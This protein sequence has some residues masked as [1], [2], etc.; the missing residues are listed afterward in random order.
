MFMTPRHPLHRL[1]LALLTTSLLLWAE[2]GR[3]AANEG[4]RPSIVTAKR[5]KN[6]QV[7]DLIPIAIKVEGTTEVRQ[8][9]IRT[10]FDPEFFE[11][12]R[13]EMGNHPEH[14]MICP[15]DPAEGSLELPCFLPRV[16]PLH[17]E[18]GIFVASGGG[19]LLDGDSDTS[20]AG[21]L[22]TMIFR[23]I[24]D[25]G[26]ESRFISVLSV[27]VAVSVD[28]F[29]IRRFD[30]G[31]FGVEAVL[32]FPNKIF[33]V[34]IKAKDI[35]AVATWRTR[36][37]GVDDIVTIDEISEDG[38]FLATVGQFEPPYIDRAPEALQV[39]R[40]LE[41]AGIDVL[42][43]DPE[44]IR[45]FVGFPIPPFGPDPFPALLEE[46]K[47]IVKQFRARLHVVPITGLAPATLYRATIRSTGLSGRDSPPQRA[48]FRTRREPDLRKL[49]A[50][51]LDIQP[52]RTWFAVKFSTNRL[53]KTNYTVATVGGSEVDNGEVNPDGADVTI[54]EVKGLTP[55]TEY[56]VDIVA[57]LAGDIPAE[58]PD[59]DARTTLRKQIKTRLARKALNMAGVPFKIVGPESALIKFKTPLPVA[60]VVFYGPIPLDELSAKVT[61]DGGDMDDRYDWSTDGPATTD[62]EIDLTAL[63]PETEYRYK[64][65][66]ELTD[67]EGTRSFSTDPLGNQQWSRDLQFAT[68]RAD[69]L[70]E[71][72][73]ESGPRVFTRNIIAVVQFENDVPT[74]AVATVGTEATFGTPDQFTFSDGLFSH[75]HSIILSGLEQDEDYLF[76]LEFTAANGVTGTFIGAASGAG[77]ATGARQPPGGGGS[78]TTTNFP[79]TQFPVILSGPT[80][81]SKTHD[82]AI[83]EWTTDEP[84]DSDIQFGTE[85]LDD[86]ETSGV[87]ETDHKITLANLTPGTTYQYIVA[88]TD[89]SGNGATESAQ[90]VFT[91]D[92]EVDLI[93]PSIVGTPAIGYRNDNSATVQWT[94]DEETTGQVEFG[95][96]ADL[97][98]IRTLP[99]TDTAHEITLTNL[100]ASTTYFYKVSSSDLSN[101]G[102]T[103]ST[104]LAFAT[105]AAPD[106]TPPTITNVQVAED[107]TSAILTWDTNE[108]A[109]SF[110]DFGTISGLLTSTVGDVQD[111]KEHEITLTNLAP[112][113]TYFYTVGSVDRANNP[114]RESVQDQFTTLA[115]A[116]VTPPAQP[117]SLEGTEGSEQVVLSWDANDELD[118][119]GY[120]LERRVAGT[121]SFTAIASGL[122]QPTYTDLGLTN[123]TTYEYRVVAVDRADNDSAESAPLSLTPVSSAAP[124][125]PTNL[126]RTG[127]LRPTFRFANAEPFVADATLTYTVQVSTQE[128]FSDV[129]DSESGVAEDSDGLTTWTITRDLVEGG[130]YYW[131][132]RALEGA[133]IGPWTAPQVFVAEAVFLVADF[134]GDLEVNFDDF[135]RFVDVFGDP[136]TGDDA[137][138]DLDHDGSVDFDDFFIFV[139]HFGDTATAG[140]AWAYAHVLDEEAR[141]WLEARGSAPMSAGDGPAA[142][143]TTGAESDR[144]TVRVLADQVRDLE[145][146]ALVVD[147]DPRL[148]RFASAR[149]GAGALLESQG[150]S[151]PLFSVLHQ[152]KGELLMGNGLI[153]GEPVSGHGV[154]AELTF[155]TLATPT[156][157]QSYFE[158][159]EAFIKGGRE[160][161]VR[162]VRDVSSTQLLPQE[163]F[164]GANYPNPFNPATHI[165]FALPVPAAVELKVYDVLGQLVRTLVADDQHPAGFYSVVWDGLNQQHQAVG[166]GIYFYRLSTPAF[167]QAGRMTLL[168]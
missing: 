167:Q 85:A 155:V 111:V 3:G 80:V 84:A 54:F 72:K 9:Q 148:V 20:G 26:D 12:V 141:L 50:H 28:D 100:E 119:A 75:E 67:D 143:A 133:L 125:I 89:A 82:T 63:D 55:A 73:I 86:Q 35:S 95:T 68:P 17:E 48:P 138:F 7:G 38:T 59:A 40:D 129:T 36:D 15:A 104:V 112:A 46:A 154:L 92:P 88:S 94:T 127:A 110:V 118:L 147:Y 6:P 160:E 123:Q 60:P 31:Q 168:K 90:A 108:L 109:D 5:I 41:A 121:G 33:E 99:E 57:E 146:Y 76:G 53:V 102:P 1:S 149:P 16:L 107:E 81:A 157:G 27:R 74:R 79:D 134:N 61:Q 165:N 145:A 159:R 162:R 115:T 128:D 161:A 131:R 137:V 10:T 103:E 62:H 83:I 45:N 4:F 14:P 153:D 164:L 2:E 114:P 130:T 13:F 70:F 49:L 136:V 166:S 97:G 158:L 52:G 101:N 39:L 58:L 120:R 34:D 140:K 11:F 69:D 150:G 105:D 71:P 78:F 24:Q 122:E 32:D 29:D 18:D 152:R 44:V 19:I 113:T 132:V 42:T 65:E 106:L 77:K 124:T 64:I 91:T 8:T 96:D 116:D 151:A 30:V 87:S 144:I 23:L 66:F 142:T 37:Q 93:A 56:V 51:G 163:F 156:S 22:G 21:V 126:A 135:F 43:A 98:F 117:S 47:V 25:I 139:D